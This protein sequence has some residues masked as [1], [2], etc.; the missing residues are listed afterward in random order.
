MLVIKRKIMV[1]REF[2]KEKMYL[3]SGKLYFRMVAER[4][5]PDETV[6]LYLFKNVKK[7]MK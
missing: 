7:I 1:V 4:G 2:F 3:D 6:D 5:P